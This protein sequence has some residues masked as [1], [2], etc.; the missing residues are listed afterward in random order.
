MTTRP[1]GTKAYKKSESSIVPPTI[2]TSYAYHRK[3]HSDV[4]TIFHNLG[5]PQLFL[6]FT[7]DDTAQ[8]MR[9]ATGCFRPWEDPIFFANHFKRKWHEFFSKYL[10]K[11][12]GRKIGGIRDY[13]W[14]MEIQD[15]G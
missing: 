2:R 13:S 4:K 11:K 10:L 3:N 9:N 12:W 1:D 15:R 7:C 8:N 5:E 14:V 6:T